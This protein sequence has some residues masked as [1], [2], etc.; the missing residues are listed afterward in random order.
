MKPEMPPTL[1]KVKLPVN[2]TAKKVNTTVIKTQYTP[3]VEENKTHFHLTG[4]DL[5]ATQPFTQLLRQSCSSQFLS[6]HAS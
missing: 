5:M 2:K 4:S 1:Q 3:T 6:S